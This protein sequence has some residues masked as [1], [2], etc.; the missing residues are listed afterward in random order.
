[1]VGLLLRGRLAE[2]ELLEHALDPLRVVGVHLAAERGD[3]I[4]A[5]AGMVALAGGPGLDHVEPTAGQPAELFGLVRQTSIAEGAGA[6]AGSRRASVLL[7]ATSIARLS[8][9]TV[10]FTCPGYSRW[11]SISRDRRRRQQD[12]IGRAHV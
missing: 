5:H 1:H 7:A 2:A 8:R 6:C 3:V 9:I 12:Q 11:S 10:T 4:A